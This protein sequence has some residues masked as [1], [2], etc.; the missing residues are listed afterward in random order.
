MLPYALVF[1]SSGALF[2]QSYSPPNFLN[3]IIFGTDP[4]VALCPLKLWS[5]SALVLWS[6]SPI[7]L[8]IS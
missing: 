8:W 1:K 4:Y 6:S 7:A 5:L 2:F 3:W